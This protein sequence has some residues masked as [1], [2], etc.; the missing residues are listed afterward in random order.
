[1]GAITRVFG[2]NHLA[3]AGPRALSKGGTY[4]RDFGENWLIG[5]ADGRHRKVDGD[6]LVLCQPPRPYPVPLAGH[7]HQATAWRGLEQEFLESRICPQN[8]RVRKPRAIYS[9]PGASPSLLRWGEEGKRRGTGAVAPAAHPDLS[10]TQ[11]CTSL[12]P[13]AKHPAR[14]LFLALG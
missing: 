11:P 2:M 4:S 1:M 14:A 13:S 6:S 8:L 7:Q 9:C 10:K 3:E 12:P 5:K